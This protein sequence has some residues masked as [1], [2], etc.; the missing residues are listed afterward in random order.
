MKPYGHHDPV[1][2]QHRIG[3]MKP[4]EFSTNEEKSVPLFVGEVKLPP[5]WIGLIYDRHALAIPAA[6]GGGGK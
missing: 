2:Q 6:G 1:P 5:M 4:D 3:N